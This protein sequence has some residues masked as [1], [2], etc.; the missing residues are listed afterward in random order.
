MVTGWKIAP[1]DWVA[2]GQIIALVET[3]KIVSEIESEPEATVARLI[4]ESGEVYPVGAR[5]AVRVGEEQGV[6]AWVGK[7]L[8]NCHDWMV[9]AGL[10]G[11]WPHDER[12]ARERD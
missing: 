11:R 9:G 7:S 2:K 12:L 8:V 1:G 5:V 6:G 3:D 10:V 4:A